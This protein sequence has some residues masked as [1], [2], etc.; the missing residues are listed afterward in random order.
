MLRELFETLANF[1][2]ISLVQFS[3]TVLVNQSKLSNLIKGIQL[4]V[5]LYAAKRALKDSGLSDRFAS[6]VSDTL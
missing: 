4:D 1:V 2:V 5:M 6:V 3:D